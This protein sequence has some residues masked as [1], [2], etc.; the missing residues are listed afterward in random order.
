M[1]RRVS[2][3]L[4][5]VVLLLPVC[6]G[7]AQSD[8][9]SP[10][11]GQVTFFIKSRDGSTAEFADAAWQI[12]PTFA[13]D[14]RDSLFTLTLYTDAAD[15]L[16]DH[17]WFR[18]IPIGLETRTYTVAGIR[19]PAELYAG[20]RLD[21]FPVNLDGSLTIESVDDRDGV[22]SGSFELRASQ[23]DAGVSG[24]FA[25]LPLIPIQDC[26]TSGSNEDGVFTFQVEGSK[27]IP[28]YAL[29]PNEGGWIAQTRRTYVDGGSPY[30]DLT[31]QNTLEG[32]GMRLEISRILLDDP[33]GMYDAR[34]RARRS[35]TVSLTDRASF[36]TNLVDEGVVDLTFDA[37]AGTLSG[38]F[39][40]FVIS[41]NGETE[42]RVTGS[43]RGLPMPTRLCTVQN[44]D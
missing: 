10:Q 39:E 43:F 12:E 5:L 35:V 19:G 37:E 36:R 15:T 6:I 9:A 16:E 4:L 13:R 20:G 28:S 1:K 42:A 44:Y 31:L 14:A 22:F 40:L 32:E 7:A 33:G 25:D 38:E 34:S 2:E 21:G 41:L 30:I 29:P 27:T 24:T 3:F 8:E 23:F 17:V 18:D 26:R 11:D